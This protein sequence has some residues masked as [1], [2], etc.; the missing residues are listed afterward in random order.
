MAEDQIKYTEKILLEFCANGTNARISDRCVC[1]NYRNQA[2]L[3]FQ[4]G[5]PIEEIQPAF[6]QV[7]RRKGTAIVVQI[8]DGRLE[9]HV[10]GPHVELFA[11]LVG[12]AQVAGRAS[13]DDIVPGGQPTLGAGNEVIKCQFVF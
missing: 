13:S 3:R 4:F 12:F 2:A 1:V 6:M 7:I 11:G 5:V 10:H 9:R 8:M